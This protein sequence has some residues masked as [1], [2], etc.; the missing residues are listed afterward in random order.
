MSLP[1]KR[2]RANAGFT[3][4][5]LMISLALL[6]LLS[7]VAFTS[8]NLSLKAV[9]RGQ[10]AAANLQELRVGQSFLERSLSSAVGGIKEVKEA[11]QYFWGD[12]QE[13]RFFTFLPLEAYNLGGIYHWRVLVGRDKAGQ[14]AVAVEQCRS[15]N[16]MQNPEVVEL[17]Q[18]LLTNVA[19]VRFFYGQDGKEY[20]HWDARR[21]GG[22]PQWVR[23]QL[24]L[25]S[26][27]PRDWIIPIH[28][29][30]NTGDES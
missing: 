20:N 30:V 2:P 16:W 8:L 29:K 3:L 15:V 25:G 26:Q 13:I 7:L 23:V 28:V 24:A 19:S 4:L 9:G 21:Q 1:E 12:P 10:A 22:P 27:P 17:R 14:G 18:I 5:E 6:S 11:R